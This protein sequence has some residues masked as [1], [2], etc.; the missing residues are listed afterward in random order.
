YTTIEAI[1]QGTPFSGAGVLVHTVRSGT[2][3]GR[4]GFQTGDILVAIDG[5][6][7]DKGQTLGGLIQPHRVGDTITCTVRR[8]NQTLA[9]KATLEERPNT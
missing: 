8:G 7:I 5:V 1:E 3:A 4:A 6:A 2:P 9:L